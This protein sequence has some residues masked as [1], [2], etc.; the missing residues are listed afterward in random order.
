MQHRSVT[1][2]PF[3]G[4]TA[5]E[6]DVDPMSGLANLADVMLVFAC[7][8]MLALVM[9]WNVD[10]TPNLTEISESQKMDEVQ[11]DLEQAQKSISSG[12]GYEELGVVYRDPATGKMYMMSEKKK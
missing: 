1:A 3:A 11:D 12:S 4:G 5:F 7:G 10:I 2:S 9:Y 6:E 8:L